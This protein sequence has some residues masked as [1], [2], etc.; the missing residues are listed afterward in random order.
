VKLTEERLREAADHFEATGRWPGVVSPADF[1]QIAG[2][3]ERLR[4]M[5]FGRGQCEDGE[6]VPGACGVCD[7]SDGR[8]CTVTGRKIREPRPWRYEGEEPEGER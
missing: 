8:I 6:P 1:R 5:L 3:L 2:E 4:G 7:L